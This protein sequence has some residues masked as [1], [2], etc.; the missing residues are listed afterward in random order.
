MT[1]D[2]VELGSRERALAAPPSVVW[3]SLADPRSAVARPWLELLDD[4]IEPLV[5]DSH[6]P[7]LVVWS[8]LWPDRP[9]ERIRFEPAPAPDGEGSMLRWTLTSCGPAPTTSKIGH[10]RFRINYLVN[11]RLRLSYGQ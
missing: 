2:V 3:A 7:D 6:R 11:G 4:E 1:D 5:L 9:N 8:T 10:M